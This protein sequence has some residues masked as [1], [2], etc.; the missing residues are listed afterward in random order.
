MVATS[1]KLYQG[2]NGMTTWIEGLRERLPNAELWAKH[3]R[4]AGGEA[5]LFKVR[6]SIF[7]YT[8]RKRL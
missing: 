2:K 5:S 7:S 8:E 1:T 4:R 3:S 6:Y